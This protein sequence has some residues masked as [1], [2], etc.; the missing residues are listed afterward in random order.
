MEVGLFDLRDSRGG[1]D[2]AAF[3]KYTEFVVIDIPK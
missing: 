1:A 3:I 2:R